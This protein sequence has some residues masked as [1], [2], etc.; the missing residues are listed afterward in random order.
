M[1]K[2]E[3]NKIRSN[4]AI[5]KV[6]AIRISTQKLGL[7]AS[8]IRNMKVDKAFAQLTFSKKKVAKEVKSCL[9]AAV[10]NAENN[11][12]LNIDRLYIAKVL[13][14]KAFI[15]KRMMPRAKGRG[16]RIIKPF[17]RLTIILE[18]R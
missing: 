9:N 16:C 8:L 12:N 5:A 6:K 13:V 1:V 18:E 3:D 14:G 15:M 11:N 10:A 7:L 4:Q 17:S 2:K